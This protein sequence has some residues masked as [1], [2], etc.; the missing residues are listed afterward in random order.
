MA[1]NAF[2]NLVRVSSQPSLSAFG[3]T[4]LDDLTG[5]CFLAFAAGRLVR[6][7]PVADSTGAGMGDYSGWATPCEIACVAA[8]SGG[9]DLLPAAE[10]REGGSGWGPDWKN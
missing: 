5:S 3:Q 7:G 9:V 2:W 6:L 4:F 10:S 8:M 1:S